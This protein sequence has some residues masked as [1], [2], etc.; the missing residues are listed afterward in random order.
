MYIYIH[1]YVLDYPL[2]R[3]ISFI[4]FTWKCKILSEQNGPNV[5]SETFIC[6]ITKGNSR[7]TKTVNF[8][9][10]PDRKME[11][12]NLSYLIMNDDARRGN[13]GLILTGSGSE[14]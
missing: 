12:I 9:L 5:E 7:G 3:R 8:S 1:N 14:K 11:P 2:V 6:R 10:Q 13:T 4:F